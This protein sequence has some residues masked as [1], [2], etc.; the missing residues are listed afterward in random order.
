MIWIGARTASLALAAAAAGMLAGCGPRGG[1]PKWRVNH[2]LSSPADLRRV[3]RIVFVELTPEPTCPPEVAWQTTQA[4]YKALQHKSLFH[5]DLVR[6]ADPICHELPIGRVEAFSVAELAKIRQ[7]LRCDAVLFGRVSH[8]KPFPAMQM[9][10][11]LKLLYLKE[12]RAIWAVD[13]VWDTTDQDTEWRIRRYF[14]REI[15]S[16]YDPLG[17]E[18]ILKS[19]RAFERY[20]AYEL[21]ETLPAGYVPHTSAD[22]RRGAAAGASAGGPAKKEQP[23]P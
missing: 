19:P 14:A 23:N 21:A 5:V 17:W 18:L 22:R 12:A 15:R 3:G 13:H 2:F 4:V 10:L 6:Q 11:Y 20:V 9:G 1:E 16:G 7:A 8:F